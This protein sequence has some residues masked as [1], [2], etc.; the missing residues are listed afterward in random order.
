MGEE[1][2]ARSRR[3]GPPGVPPSPPHLSRPGGCRE[4][5]GRKPD[6]S[7][8][9]VSSLLPWA[10]HPLWGPAVRASGP[11]PAPCCAPGGQL[12]LSPW[13]AVPSGPGSGPASPPAGLVRRDLAGCRQHAALSLGSPRPS[14]SLALPPSRKNLR[15]PPRPGS[16]LSLPALH[17]RASSTR[18]PSVTVWSLKRP[19]GSRLTLQIWTVAPSPKPGQG[20]C[21]QVPARSARP[22]QHPPHPAGG[23]HRTHRTLTQKQ[24][25]QSSRSRGK[26]LCSLIQST[27]GR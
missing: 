25:G 9:P 6:A 20:R 24:E 22:A 21:G 2:R 7:R 18:E 11:E 19:H 15:G 8:C 5:W 4:L 27:S 1:G 23:P 17:T 16:P 14:P 13:C 12:P 3:S 26:G 10:P